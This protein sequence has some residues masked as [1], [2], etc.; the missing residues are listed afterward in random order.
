[1]MLA[2]NLSAW[3]CTH[4]S[5]CAALNIDHFYFDIVYYLLL[6]LHALN[7]KGRRLHLCR[8]TGT[9]ETVHGKC[10]F[11]GCNTSLTSTKE[12]YC[13]KH[14]GSK[15]APCSVADC[16]T[17]SQRK[18]LCVKHGGGMGP[19]FISGCPNQIVSTKIMTC[20]SHG[21]LGY[22]TLEECWTPAIKKGGNCRKH[23]SK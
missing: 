21:G 2:F 23:T 3:E 15:M 10:Q 17:P 9:A 19:C 16:A 1:M 18:G 5:N 11:A 14:G 4:H 6:V 7:F 20:K 12:S 22:C 8:R 13:K